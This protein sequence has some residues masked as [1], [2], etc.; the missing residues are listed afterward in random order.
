[1]AARGG[2]GADRGLRRSWGSTC[3]LWGLLGG[4]GRSRLR[5]MAETAQATKDPRLVP[6]P[7]GGALR[8]V[9]P[10][11]VLNPKGRPS[12][13]DLLVKELAK[14]TGTTA[15]YKL[16][17]KMRRGDADRFVDAL[18]ETATRSGARGQMTAQ[19]VIWRLLGQLE[20]KLEVK[21]KIELGVAVQKVR[22]SI[23]GAAAEPTPEP[24]TI[25]AEARAVTGARQDG[26]R[27]APRD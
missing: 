26:R 19:Q 20:E 1:M 2:P 27:T 4:E 9:R 25:D 7:H 8:P 11:E 22:E 23:D 10:G 16:T 24:R 15:L 17:R 5:A 21:G 3:G 13:K 18:I 6:Q 12:R 14:R